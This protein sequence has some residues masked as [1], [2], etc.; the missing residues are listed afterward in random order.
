M[1]AVAPLAVLSPNNN[2]VGNM[3]TDNIKNVP[4]PVF[5]IPSIEL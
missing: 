2:M 3:V 5:V 1:A 4:V